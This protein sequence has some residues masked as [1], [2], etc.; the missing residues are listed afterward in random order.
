MGYY[1]LPKEKRGQY[2]SLIENIIV[3]S[4][5]SN[6]TNEAVPFLSDNDAYVRKVAYQ[7]IGTLYKQ[8]KEIRPSIVAWLEQLYGSTDEKVRQTIIYACGE[9]AGI[10][11]IAIEKLLTK[12]MCDPHH[13]VKNA[14]IGSLKI[15]GKRNPDIIAF[16]EKYILSDDPEIRRLICHGLELRGREHPQEIIGFLKKLQHDKNKRVRQMLIHVLGQI[17]YKKGC[18][19]FVESEVF[20]WGN[21]DIYSAF[22]KEVVEVHGRYEKFSEL[23]KNDVIKFFEKKVGVP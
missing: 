21:D 11:F 23:S 6:T 4:V 19:Y 16:C 8:N 3:S 12:G 13:S 5:K 2:K 14:F 17:S 20:S 10:D 7:S 22:E 1:D 18:F 15:S 9:I